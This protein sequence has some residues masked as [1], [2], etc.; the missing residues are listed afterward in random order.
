MPADDTVSWTHAHG[1]LYAWVALPA[2][3]DTSR[4]SAMFNRC[5]EEGVLYVPG[6]Y[7]FQPDERG[8]IP[9]NHLRLSFGQVAPDQI[10]P[11]IERLADVVRSQLS[12]VSSSDPLHT[13][14]HGSRTHAERVR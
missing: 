11:G 14:D 12:V 9:T 5:V 7:C 3:F 6:A 4:G 10:V 2:G 13:S 1:G 8:V